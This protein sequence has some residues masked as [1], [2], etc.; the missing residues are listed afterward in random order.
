MR[1]KNGVAGYLFFLPGFLFFAVF[2]LYPLVRNLIYSFYDFRL[3]DLNHLEFI[4]FD[5]YVNVFTDSVFWVS[6][7]NI[8][9]YGLISVPGQMIIG[10]FVAYALHRNGFGTKTFRVLYFLPVITSWVVASLIFKF[11]FTDQGYLNYFIM[12]KLHF[13]D[14][15]ISW[16]SDPNKALLVVGFLG[17]WKGIGW[18]MVIYMAALQ[19]VPVDQYE[20]ASLDGCN[21]WNK[22]RY[23]TLP[24]IRSTTFFIQ[25]MLIIGA[26]N[27]FTSIYLI[28]DGGPLHQ[29]E[30][31]LTRMY[32]KAFTEYDLGYASAL[33][34]VFA[35]IIAI[36]TFI[37]FRLNKED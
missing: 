23:I 21:T 36:L 27:V 33:S 26:F 25:M 17:I 37:Q 9:I 22:I 8:V 35:I 24:A 31:M 19:G 14:T 34:Y 10:F 20:A 30:V 7:K 15:T 18:V 5:N 16:L 2:I 6:L 11:V 32:Q 4:G 13:T 12:D 29:T 1:K 28:T 3:S